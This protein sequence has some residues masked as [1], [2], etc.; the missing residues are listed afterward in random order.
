MAFKCSRLPSD[1]F[2]LCLAAA[3]LTIAAPG[4]VAAAATAALELPDGD[5]AL[6]GQPSCAKSKLRLRP[7]RRPV[8]PRPLLPPLRAFGLL[9]AEPAG[10]QPPWGELSKPLG[11]GSAPGSA[12][13]EAWRCGKRGVGKCGATIGLGTALSSSFVM[14]PRTVKP[15]FESAV[16]GPT[17]GRPIVAFDLN[18]SSDS[19]AIWS[20]NM[21]LA[22]L[23]PRGLKTGMLKHSSR[24]LGA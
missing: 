21:M 4:G 13:I 12:G 10:L 6:V 11:V 1:G 9:A 15:V 16:L 5:N 2:P 24:G 17:L 20:M 3:G 8:E 18:R 22:A 7:W 19:F 23:L 14:Y